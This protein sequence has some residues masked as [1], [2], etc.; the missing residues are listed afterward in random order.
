MVFADRQIHSAHSDRI[1]MPRVPVFS[2]VWH[3]D[4]GLLLLILKR[5][6]YMVLIKCQKTV[7]YYFAEKKVY[8]K[9]L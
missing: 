8:L 3:L 2:L 5:I 6:L 7:Y 9:E 1:L 4:L